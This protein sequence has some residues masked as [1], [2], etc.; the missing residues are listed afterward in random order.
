MGFGSYWHW[1]LLLLLILPAWPTWKICQRMG[2]PGPL[3]LLI[4]IPIVNLV[5][6]WVLAFVDWPIERRAGRTAERST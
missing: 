5:L 6:I 3:G 1:L 4:V 2:L